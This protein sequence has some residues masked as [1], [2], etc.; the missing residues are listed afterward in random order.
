MIS[1]PYVTRIVS[2]LAIVITASLAVQPAS[3]SV[4][5]APSRAAP[6]HASSVLELAYYDGYDPT[7]CD[8]GAVTTSEDCEFGASRD[9]W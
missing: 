1:T 7:Y 2:A 8:V 3:A 4:I 9:G 6:A 5:S